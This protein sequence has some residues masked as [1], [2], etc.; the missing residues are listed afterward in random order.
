M[1][2]RCGLLALQRV[3]HGHR[4]GMPRERQL[5]GKRRTSHF[6]QVSEAAAKPS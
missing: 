2:S 5:Q 3:P 1:T 4:I 6:V